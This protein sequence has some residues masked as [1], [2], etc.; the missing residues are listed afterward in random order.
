[1][2]RG[3]DRPL[4]LLKDEVDRVRGVAL[5]VR[6]GFPAYRQCSCECGCS[7]VIV[8]RICSSSHNFYVFG[9][10]R[11]PDLSENIYDC[12]LTAMAKVDSVILIMSSGLGLLRR[13]C[14]KGQHLTLHI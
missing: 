4:Q 2:I 14:T 5:Y 10:Y 1:M 6:E 12:F 9:V 3:F 8:V 13:L 11:K 7:E